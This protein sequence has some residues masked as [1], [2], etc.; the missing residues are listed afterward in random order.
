MKIIELSL[1][2]VNKTVALFNCERAISGVIHT[3]EGGNTTVIVGGDYV[4]GKFDCPACAIDRITDLAINIKELDK[5]F[6]AN[7]QQYKKSISASLF[8]TVH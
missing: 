1:E 7:Y 6:G 3:V 8:P 2:V 5:A 4:L